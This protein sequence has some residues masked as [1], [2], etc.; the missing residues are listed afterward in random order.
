MIQRI[1]NK[2]KRVQ[3]L[4]IMVIKAIDT[5]DWKT[6]IVHTT[7]NK[8]TVGQTPVRRDGNQFKIVGGPR[9]NSFQPAL[10]CSSR[11]KAGYEMSALGIPDAPIHTVEEIARKFSDVI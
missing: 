10:V 11:I 9:N 4:N 2:T 5:T 6:L 7:S 3:N 8:A 1:R